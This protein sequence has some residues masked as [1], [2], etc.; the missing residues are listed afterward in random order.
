MVGNY[1][2]ENTL[3]TLLRI[4]IDESWPKPT[5]TPW[6]ML[7]DDGRLLQEGTSE[8]THWPQADECDFVLSAPQTAW[9]KGRVPEKIPRGEQERVLAYAFEE[10][11][12]HEPGSQHFTITERNGEELGVVVTARV[13]LQQ[14][15]ETLAALDRPASRAFSEFHAAH[16]KVGAWHLTLKHDGAMLRR[17]EGDGLA[18]DLGPEG[19]PPQ[20]LKV[21]LSNLADGEPLPY[22]ILHLPQGLDVPAIDDWSSTLG[23]EV[24]IGEPHEWYRIKDASPSL[25]HG[26]FT[27]RH[28]RQAWISRVQPALWLVAGALVLDLVFGLIHVAWQRHQINT[29][30]E[31]VSQIFQRSFPNTPTINPVAQMQRQLDSLRE[32]FGQLRSDD[33]LL[34]LS[35]LGDALGT[36]GREAVQS[37]RFDDNV[38]ELTLTPLVATRVGSIREQLTRQGFSID[39][40]VD[41][42]GGPKLVI[43]KRAKS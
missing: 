6:V 25:L 31:K 38:L 17:N 40:K 3:N 11:L 29:I 41:G 36:D 15:I 32:Q 9:L 10:K 18:L 19:D 8:P 14:L 28:H 12:L 21:L 33:A 7:G 37:L 23:I 39:V 35:A 42:E 20:L 43:R 27:P 13:R 24:S 1:L 34:M 16:S 2:A 5:K 30:N 26:E 4:Y 22:L